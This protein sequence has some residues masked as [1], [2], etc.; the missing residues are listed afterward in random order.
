MLRITHVMRLKYVRKAYTGYTD[1]KRKVCVM[2][3]HVCLPHTLRTSHVCS[4][5][6]VE[7]M[8]YLN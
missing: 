5:T 3:A 6:F 1:V 7:Y 2:Y 8:W 4:L